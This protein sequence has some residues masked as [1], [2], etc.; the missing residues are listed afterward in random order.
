[1]P[2]EQQQPKEQPKPMPPAQPQPPKKGCNCGRK[3]K[4]GKRQ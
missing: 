3:K 1:M 4:E 2:N